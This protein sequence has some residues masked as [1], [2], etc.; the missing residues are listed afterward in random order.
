MLL[1]AVCVVCIFVVA[2][3]RRNSINDTTSS[4]TTKPFIPYGASVCLAPRSISA[5]LN[6][7]SHQNL[8][9]RR[10]QQQ[11]QNKQQQG[12]T[13]RR[14][15]QIELL[16]ASN[17]KHLSSVHFIQPNKSQPWWNTA[18]ERSSMIR[19]SIIAVRSLQSR[20]LPINNVS[21]Q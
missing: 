7:L 10:K 18:S 3:L 11:Q 12:N 15:I 20:R 13:E 17:P 2:T 16:T 5:P 4:A 9:E 6:A 1:C 14:S 8:R 21:I 19:T